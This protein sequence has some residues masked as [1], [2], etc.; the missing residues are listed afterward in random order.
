MTSNIR[1]LPASAKGNPFL[2][3]VLST[4]GSRTTTT[5]ETIEQLA[6]AIC[7]IRYDGMWVSRWVVDHY[8]GRTPHW[9]RV[10]LRAYGP[11]GRA[12]DPVQLCDYGARLLTRRRERRHSQPLDRSNIRGQGSVF[13]VHCR[14]GGPRFSHP[15]TM[16][17]RRQN[18]GWFAEEG[19]PEVRARRRHNYLPNSR[20]LRWRFVQH[21]WKEQSKGRKSWD[22]A[23]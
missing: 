13:G 4:S 11:R 16:A 20:D 23:R 21:S 12:F 15:Q 8:Q 5:Y 9:L 1:P 7:R 3:D 22:R 2:L 19:E 18:T 14:R 17:E 10:H 6:R